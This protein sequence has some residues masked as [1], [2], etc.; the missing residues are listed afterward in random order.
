[1]G[2][3]VSGG[4]AGRR[5]VLHVG[6]PKS[7]T[8]FLQRSMWARR[9]ALRAVGVEPVGDQAREMFHA[10][11]EVRGTQR[12]WRLES[13]EIEGTWQRL[14]D[15]AR[16]ATGTVVMSHET[17]AAA[18][19]SRA[20]RAME[21]LSGLEVHL[22]FTA[23]DLVRQVPSEWQERIKNGGTTSFAT[24]QQG[25]LEEIRS[26]KTDSGFWRAQDVLSVLER[27]GHDVPPDRTHVVVA[28]PS[29]T[30]PEVL[31]QRFA[32]AVGFDGERIP[33]DTQRAP[34][35]RTLGAVQTAL[36]RKVN[37]TLDG[38]IPQPHYAKVVKRSFSQGL[39]AQQRSAP[40]E[41]LPELRDELRER[42][43]EQVAEIARRGFRVH[44]D[45]AE[46]VPAPGGGNGIDPDAVDP[47][48][49][50][51]AAVVAIADLLEARAP[52]RARRS[53]APDPGP[54]APSPS[55]GTGLRSRLR[56]LRRGA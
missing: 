44:G 10:A 39:L 7:G 19:R 22:V 16:R 37:L 50:G 55:A 18:R 36:L 43:R 45:P 31:W 35:N 48:E 9:E 20:A 5:V 23:R 30:A 21:A 4:D 14:C 11:I 52:H 54:A 2:P 51:A 13:S 49:W 47:D 29:G 32:E 27:W 25:L 46:L 12:F 6:A 15:R 1:M 17:L 42:A 3:D 33:P 34:S 56:R 53:A 26:G 38:R 24:F 28:P 8:T 40:I 41:C